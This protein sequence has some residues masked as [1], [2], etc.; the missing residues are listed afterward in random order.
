MWIV[1]VKR[2]QVFYMFEVFPNIVMYMYMTMF[3]NVLAWAC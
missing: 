2:K 3:G 1:A